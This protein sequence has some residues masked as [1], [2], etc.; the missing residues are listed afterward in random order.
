MVV[1]YVSYPPPADGAG[2]VGVFVADGGLNKVFANAEPVTHDNWNYE[3][4]EER[5]DRTYVRV[6]FKRLSEVVRDYLQPGDAVDSAASEVPLGALSQY[7]GAL[8]ATS[9]GTGAEAQAL[10]GS[11]TGG[12]GSGG[13]QRSVRL[14]LGGTADLMQRNGE[15]IARFPMRIKGLSEPGKICVAVKPFVVTAD[16]AVE[17]E[18]PAGADVPRVVAWHT[19]EG[20]QDAKGNE[21]RVA[22]QSNDDIAVLVSVP[23]NAAVSISASVKLIQRA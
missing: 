17:S 16:G 4:L 7:L 9:S 5:N 11:G 10:G 20:E 2:M 21:L 19:A 18:S 23:A 8:V 12:S 3:S 14:E 15:T 6:T 1:K 13:S 22:A